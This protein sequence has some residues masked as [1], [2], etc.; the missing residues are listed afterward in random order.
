MAGCCFCLVAAASAN[1][2]PPGHTFSGPEQATRIVLSSLGLFGLFI[3][4]VTTVYMLLPLRFKPL[5]F[6]GAYLTVNAVSWLLFVAL[7][8]ILPNTLLMLAILE[9]LVVFAE[10]AALVRLAGYS[11][12]CRSG[13][14]PLSWHRAIGASL[15]GVG[16]LGTD[17]AYLHRDASEGRNRAKA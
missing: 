10:A 7:L 1:S 4:E 6:A 9:L 2:P 13:P 3:V 15:A 14:E 17:R 16:A 11:S 12:L 5:R 8:S